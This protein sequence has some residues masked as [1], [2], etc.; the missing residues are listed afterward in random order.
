MN[1]IR[2]TAV[3]LSTI[4]AI[5]YK[6][7]LAAGGAGL[8]ILRMDTDAVAVFTIDRRTGEAEPYGTYD[9]ELFPPDA[10]AE[11]LELISG[12]PYTAR[13]KIK[14]SVS[15]Q[16]VNS[17]EDVLETETEK[18]DM[19]DTPEYLA[20]INGY[21]GD[22]GK[23]NYT[24][25]NKDFIQFASR[26]TVVGEMLAARAHSDEILSY[27]VGSRAINLSGRKESLSAV[28]VAGLIE[29]L[30]EINPRSAFKELNLHIRQLL[31]RSK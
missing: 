25:M 8:R 6:Q 3:E 20:I 5:T 29:T 24:L 22:D 30:D 18:V 2:T 19:V 15:A 13:G 17:E 14:I 28:E 21:T 31:A 11:A 27:V 1:I 9:G 16:A 12:L 26:S 10:V 23:L 4:P 7:K